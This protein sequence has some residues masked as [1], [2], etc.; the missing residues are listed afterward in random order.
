MFVSL[1]AAAVFGVPLAQQIDTVIPVDQGARLSV[2]AL[3]GKVTVRTWNRAEVRVVADPARGDEVTVRGTRSA[4]RI[5][6]MT[7]YSIGNPID[8]AITLV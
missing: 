8:I 3:S 6:A 7:P 2:H 4:V 5:E 1:L